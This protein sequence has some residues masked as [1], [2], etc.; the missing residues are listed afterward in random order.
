MRD[1]VTLL[2]GVFYIA[3][4]SIDVV[5]SCSICLSSFMPVLVPAR[6]HDGLNLNDLMRP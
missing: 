5:A 4:S 6:R 1:I 3:G 2:R